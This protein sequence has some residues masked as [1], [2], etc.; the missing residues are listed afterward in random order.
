[1][2][3]FDGSSSVSGS[4]WVRKRSPHR[5]NSVYSSR[6]SR[7]SAPSIF[8]L[9]GGGKN[10]STSSFFSA[11][12]HSR[13]GVRPRSGFI[14]RMIRRIKRLLRDIWSYARRHPVKV[15][16]F[17]IVPLITGGVLQ[18]LLAMVGLRLPSGLVGNRSEFEQISRRSSSLGGL[19]GLAGG[20]GGAGLGDSINGAT[21]CNYK[22]ILQKQTFDT[23][24]GLMHVEPPDA[25]S[26]NKLT[27]QTPLGRRFQGERQKQRLQALERLLDAQNQCEDSVLSDSTSTTFF[28]DSGLASQA[29]LQNGSHSTSP[30]FV[31]DSSSRIWD[32]FI[33]SRATQIGESPI[34][35]SSG[36]LIQ[37]QSV[38][39]PGLPLRER[40]FNQLMREIDSV[41]ETSYNQIMSGELSI[42]QIFR[43]G[44]RH[45]P[46]RPPQ[47]P[48][49]NDTFLV[50][51]PNPPLRTERI[52]V[53]E[54]KMRVHAHALPNVYANNLR[55]KQFTTISALRASIESLGL[56]FSML[57]NPDTESPF[58][59]GSLSKDAAELIIAKER[60]DD[61]APHL[62]P[63]IAQIR[64][65]HHP[66]LDGLP[67]P[68]LRE[69]IIEA[70][71][72][73]P[74][75]IDEEDL[76]NDLE[77][78]GLICWGSYLGNGNCATGSGAP[79]DYRSW[80]AQPWFLRKWWF[81][82]GGSQAE[83]FQQ[84]RWW[85]EMRGDRLVAPW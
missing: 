23:I 76:C 13:K 81:F 30:S 42:S 5:S 54:N 22:R 48:L 8:S 17:V 80:E 44:L 70:C 25:L 83:L 27:C 55:L 31:S 40:I 11:S 49:G 52:L 14:E 38:D 63:T 6:H 61:V 16:L 51:E 53:P 36:S 4:G 7:H 47:N 85:H 33:T 1:M 59:R 73:E 46:T 24:S 12:S 67:F 65:S 41:D 77:K 43:A 39:S 3:W 21:V 71:S 78:G 28:P 84:T 35:Q 2:G 68:S 69:R 62:R 29:T 37:A 50:D 57:S 74:P 79:W 19:G 15:F 60:F 66:Y 26:P 10:R 20:V 9:G 32:S 18:K 64:H 72:L 75:I 56:T 82:I 45:V 34:S 58:Y